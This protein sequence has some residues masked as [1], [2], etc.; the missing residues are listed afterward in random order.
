MQTDTAK[1]FLFDIQNSA[2]PDN[3]TFEES[4]SRARSLF[5]NRKMCHERNSQI[6]FML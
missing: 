5:R 4:S 1:L 6:Y 2:N 3:P